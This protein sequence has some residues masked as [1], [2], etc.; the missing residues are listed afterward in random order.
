LGAIANYRKA[1]DLVETPYFMMFGADDVLKDNYVATITNQ[2]KA[3]PEISIFQPGVDVIDEHGKTTKSLVDS[4][5]KLISPKAG[6]H[7]GSR[8]AASLMVGNFTYFPSLT[9]K[10][11]DV[12]T[13]GFRHNLHVTQD[14]ALICD[15][16]LRD[17]R[18]LVS[19]DPVFLYRRH[20]GS[21]SSI[22]LLTGDR[23]SEEIELSNV[24][25]KNFRA[26]GWFLAFV[27]AKARPTVRLHMLLL[28][29]KVVTKPKIF[30]KTLKGAFL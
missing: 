1:L 16:L 7:S 29:P 20:A 12:R 11:D 2:I 6:E 24:L 15:L 13:I 27:A 22:K 3:H 23:F 18:M 30:L 8:L 4:V 19:S 14:L 25:S 9:W 10:M 17:C 5:K 21:D 28:L 26:K